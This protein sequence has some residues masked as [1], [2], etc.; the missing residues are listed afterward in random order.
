VGVANVDAARDSRFVARLAGIRRRLGESAASFKSVW[1]NRRLRRLEF[2]ITATSL[3]SWGYSI[4]VSVYAFGIGGAKAVGLMWLVRMIPAALLAPVAGIVA[5]RYPRRTVML[6]S[7]ALRVGVILV[8]T[9]AVWQGWSSVVVYVAAATSAVLAAPFFAASSALLPS[10]AATPAELTAANAV[11]GIIDSVGFF[12]GP[13]IAGAVL[14][15]ANIETAFLVTVGATAL[16]FLLNTRLPKQGEGGES[17]SETDKR[18]ED[19][20]AGEALESFASH[21]LGGFRAIGADPRLAVLLGI[22]AAGCLVTGAMEVQIVSIALDLLKLGDGAVGY[23]NAAFG[24]GAMAGALVTAGLVGAR[25]LS[26]PFV[27]G[28][29]LFGAPLI[30]AA[31]PNRTAAVVALV[32]LGIGNPLIDVPCFTLLQR[33]V[34]ENVLARVFGVLQLIWSGS[35]G[36]GAVVAPALIRG[37]GIRGSLVVVGCVV[38]LIVAVL[39]TKVLQIDGEATAPPAD[40]LEL[41]QR[42][43]IFAP[44]PGATLEG[45]VGR[46]IPVEFQSGAVVIREGDHGDRFFVISEGQVDVTSGGAHVATLGPGE[47]LGEIALLR[48]VPRTATCTAKT[49]V[50][51]YA[52]TRD[53]FLGAV[54]SQA[55]SRDAADATAASR[56]AGLAARQGIAIPRG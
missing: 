7:D 46:L 29:I 43:P 37:L 39:W 24:I 27:A 4:A 11:T 13:A 48:D 18:G 17:E 22:F 42:M 50:K 16:S 19:A 56:L 41:L 15:V 14:A 2:A 38:P 30:I 26:R 20:G 54:T 5:D 6:A 1:R 34:P 51:L 28:G 32:L 52:L 12:V 53:D 44:L 49:A 33:A 55:A 36:I 3:G 10:L 35:V 45:L 31:W 23:L 21:A 40:E 25:R 9:V 8:A 47:P